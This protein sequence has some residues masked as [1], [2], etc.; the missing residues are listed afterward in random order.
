METTEVDHYLVLSPL[1]QFSQSVLVIAA[2]L[3][4]NVIEAVLKTCQSFHA[5]FENSLQPGRV[6]R[7]YL[8]S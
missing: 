1:D 8:R 7:S 5:I 4:L 6:C 2:A 3:I